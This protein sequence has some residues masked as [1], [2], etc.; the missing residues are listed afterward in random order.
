MRPIDI[1]AATPADAAE[2]IRLFGEL[3]R[4]NSQLDPRFALA[5][6]WEELVHQYL[7]QSEDS[8]DSSWLLARDNS[9]VVGFVL[10]ELHADSPLY[11][12]RYWAE[13]VGLYVDPEYRGSDVADLLME[14]AYAW[15]LRR[16][17]RI[18]QLYVTATNYQA[19]RF[20]GKQ[21]FVGTQLIMRRTL[22]ESDV[23]EAPL[24]T[25]SH[26]R[27]HFSE[28]GARPLDMHERA[29]RNHAGDSDE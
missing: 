25:H 19:Q 22:S 5:D 28:G 13:I 14:Q 15:A 9:R 8:A 10:V 1:V 11:R 26:R 23:L 18:M 4:Y 29:H 16:N 24:A 6:G 2:V 7:Q 12:H 27:L 21:G 20:Y 17:L 3:H